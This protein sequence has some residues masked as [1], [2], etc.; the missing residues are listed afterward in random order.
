MIKHQFGHT[1][2]RQHV[3]ATAG[4]ARLNAKRECR[5]YP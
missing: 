2:V 4:K 1:K 3:L 5:D